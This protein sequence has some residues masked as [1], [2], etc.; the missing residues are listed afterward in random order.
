MMITPMLA[1]NGP[2]AEDSAKWAYE[3]KWDG[4]RALVQASPGGHRLYPYELEH[5][6]LQHLMTD[7]RRMVVTIQLWLTETPPSIDA[8]FGGEGRVRTDFTAVRDRACGMAIQSDGTSWSRAKRDGSGQ[9]SPS[10]ATLGRDYVTPTQS[11]C[12]RRIVGRRGRALARR[13]V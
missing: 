13:D 2:L 7:A 8:T 4:Y 6:S 1:A 3:V 11:L 12:R 10:C 5:R 9:D